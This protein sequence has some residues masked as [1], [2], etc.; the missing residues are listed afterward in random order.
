[1]DPGLGRF[2][3]A[4]DYDVLG[5]TSDGSK[6][7]LAKYKGDEYW[8]VFIYPESDL[9]KSFKDFS[10]LRESKILFETNLYGTNYLENLRKIPL[11]DL[12]ENLLDD[13]KKLAVL[14]HIRC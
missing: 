2:H 11:E 7:R 10:F 12:R 6:L 13:E 4:S 9:S 8:D 5:V 1:M 3:K 14:G